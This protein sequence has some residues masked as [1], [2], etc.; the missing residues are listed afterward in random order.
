MLVRIIRGHVET[1]ANYA[2]GSVV[3]LPADEA[4]QKIDAGFAIPLV[5]AGV[6]NPERSNPATSKRETR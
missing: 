5:G 2:A 1:L 4:K 6:Q 3:D